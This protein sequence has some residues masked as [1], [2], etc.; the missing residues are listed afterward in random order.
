MLRENIL[1]SNRVLLELNGLTL[2]C[3]S[4]TETLSGALL[5]S[6]KLMLSASLDSYG[7]RAI[8]AE[9]P[10]APLE[11]SLFLFLLSDVNLERFLVKL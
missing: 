10:V 5:T 11:D 9:V 1:L 2:T 8:P 4:A 7:L 6:G 3:S